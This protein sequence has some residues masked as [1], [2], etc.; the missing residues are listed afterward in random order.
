[1]IFF[2]LQRTCC[3]PF[4]SFLVSWLLFSVG[5]E[6]CFVVWAFVLSVSHLGTC[7]LNSQK[8]TLGVFLLS[9]VVVPV[10]SSYFLF[11]NLRGSF[12]RGFVGPGYW[13]YPRLQVLQERERGVGACDGIQEENSSSIRGGPAESLSCIDPSTV[14]LCFCCFS[15]HFDDTI[16]ICQPFEMVP[17]PSPPNP[18]S[19]RGCF[20]IKLMTRVKEYLAK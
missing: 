2:P 14:P 11:S 20:E 1:M 4:F 8:I 19:W 9:S 7:I 3:F 5:Y 6:F 13:R 17:S 16:E 10:A 18:G 15:L 12:V